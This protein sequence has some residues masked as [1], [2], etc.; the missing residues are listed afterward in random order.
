VYNMGFYKKIRASDRLCTRSGSAVAGR[1]AWRSSAS[2]WGI[3]AASAV[4]STTASATTT[5]A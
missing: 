5:A 4:A 3:T 2:S 1:V